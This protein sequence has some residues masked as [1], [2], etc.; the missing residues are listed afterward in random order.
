MATNLGHPLAQTSGV[1]R[2]FSEKLKNI[3]A[4]AR[5]HLFAIIQSIVINSELAHSGTEG[6]EEMFVVFR[7]GAGHPRV[8]GEGSAESL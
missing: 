6:W 2:S 3:S 5:K 4:T 7:C 1:N 8:C